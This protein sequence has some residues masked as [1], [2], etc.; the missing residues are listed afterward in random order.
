MSLASCNDNAAAADAV[1]DDADADDCS[2]VRE[3]SEELSTNIALGFAVNSQAKSLYTIDPVTA[4][5]NQLGNKVMMMLLLA[6]ILMVMLLLQTECAFL[7][8]G[9]QI[10]STKYTEFR[11]Q[12]PESDAIK[13]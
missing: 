5:P 6:L 13:V 2:E 8:F 12:F 10:S 4:L 11:Q 9:D 1:D 7:Q 3:L